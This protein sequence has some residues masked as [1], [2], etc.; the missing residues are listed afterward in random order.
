MNDKKDDINSVGSKF[1]FRKGDK[2]E[3]KDGLT[4]IVV[5]LLA[6]GLGKG[7]T[8]AVRHGKEGGLSCYA[9]SDLRPAKEG[10]A[11]AD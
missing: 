11:D 8:Y 5:G 9:G 2:V 1:S 7:P 10:E 4:G 3:N 6:D